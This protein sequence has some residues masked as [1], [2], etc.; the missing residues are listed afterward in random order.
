MNIK[1]LKLRSKGY[2]EILTHIPSP[3]QELFCTGGPLAALLKRPA[4]TVVGTRRMTPYGRQATHEIVRN[5]A[6]QGIV[7][8]SGLA[9][10]VDAAAHHAALEAG[11]YCIAVLPCPLDRIVPARNR[12]LAKEILETGGTLIS[13]Y[14]PGDIPFRQNFIARNRI[15]SGLTATTLIIEATEHSGTFHTAK[16][17]ADQNRTVLAVP[18]NINA[19]ASKGTNKLI[20]I[21]RAQLVTDYRDVM[22]EM[23]LQPHQTHVRQVKG[24]NANEQKILDLML[25]GVTG[26]EDLLEA[27]G[28]SASH[29]A[30]ALTMLE[31]NGK[32]RPLGANHWAIY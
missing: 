20:K 31:I 15:M 6:E 23:D 30:Q 17:A 14:P 1:K 24:G 22:I 25:T 18:G 21:K 13:E 11:G 9:L 32:V 12:G 28:L 3:P 10:G 26:G 19:P 29:F 2:P 8:V 5:L 16:F 27:S 7:I 4:I